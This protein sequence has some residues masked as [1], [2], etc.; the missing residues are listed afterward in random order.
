MLSETDSKTYNRHFPDNPHPFISEPFI[1]LNKK[2]T[3]RVI[4][5]LDDG[6]K[7]VIGLIAGLK[8]RI[9]QSPFSAPFGGFHFRNEIVYIS[10]ID[11]FLASLQAYIT[12]QGLDGIEITLPPDIYH[13]T[14]N[15]K[16]INSLLRNGFKSTVPEI[17]NWVN[18][19]QFNGTF[20][21]KNSREYY[22]QA[23]RN[24][25]TFSLATD[26][27]EKGMVYDLICKNR[28]KF[29]RPIFM[30]YEDILDTSNLWPVDFFRIEA[31]KHKI[32]A[33]AIFYRSRPDIGYAVF[34]GDN[35][36]GRPLRA[37]DYLAFNL[38]TYYKNLG[39]KYIDLGIST[40]AGNPNE[41]LLR[42]KES[43]DATSALRFKYSW[44]V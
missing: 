32:V 23:V 8:N 43:H 37:M 9:L 34:W 7:A 21:Q 2:K 5:L 39:Y 4:R 19:S 6:N 36:E 15:A 27:R 11:S 24:G 10:E 26:E 22:R 13:L 28:A 20:C 40:E 38:W 33:S 31:T 41:G 29:G 42:F 25:L 1:E 12:Q 17:T 44:Q 30:T 18:L 35:E 16:T 14:F 3:E